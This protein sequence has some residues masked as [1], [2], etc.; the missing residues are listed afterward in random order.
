MNKPLKISLISLGSLIGLIIIALIIVF[1]V[2]LN[3]KRSTTLVN[4]YASKFISCEYEI[5]KV[6]IAFF[7]TFPDVAVEID[8]LTLENK[9]QGCKN[10]TLAF[11]EKCVASLNVKE[12]YNG[13]LVINKLDLHGGSINAFIDENGNSNFDIFAGNEGDDDEND[14]SKSYMID[15]KQ[16]KFND[17]NFVYNDLSSGI[18][19]AVNGMNLNLV[20]VVDEMTIRGDIDLKIK[21]LNADVVYD[22][23]AMSGAAENLELKSNLR[24][25]SEIVACEPW[26]AIG[27]TSF[28]M[29]G[30]SVVS[31]NFDAFA[32]KTK[33]A[34]HDMN[35]LA[36]SFINTKFDGLS[37]SLNDDDYL[38]NA[39]VTVDSKS[40]VEVSL[41][42]KTA[43][44]KDISLII[45]EY[46]VSLA[47]SVAMKDEGIAMN[48]DVNTNTIDV[49]D[50]IEFIPE[51]ILGDALDG[52]SADGKLQIKSKING[53]YNENTTPVVDAELVF[54]D[55]S[56]EMPESLPYPLTEI[57]TLLKVGLDR[58]GKAS[59]AINSLKTKM[60]RSSVSMAGTVSD[61]LRDS[62]RCSLKANIATNAD[63]IRSF[64]P[65]Y[66]GLEGAFTA[67]VEVKGSITDVMDFKFNDSQ[68]DAK[69]M[70]SDMSVNYCD[71]INLVSENLAVNLAY[72]GKGV[73]KE[74]NGYV[75][76][77]VNG[78]DLVAEVSEMM[79]VELD[80][81]DINGYASNLLDYSSVPSIITEFG[82]SRVDFEMDDINLNA[83]YSN[84][85]LAVLRSTNEG[86]V[87][88]TM[89]FGSDSLAFSMD[90][91][92]L[93]TESIALD[94]FSDY[95]EKLDNFMM[96]WNPKFDIDLSNALVDVDGIEETI[97]I[98]SIN[99]KY[100][101]KGL[102]VEDSKVVLG[103]SDFSLEGS[104]TNIAENIKNKELLRGD[105]TFTSGYSD[106][107]Q[108]LT[109]FS[110]MGST[111][112]V[113]EVADAGEE[114][115]PFM[116]PLGTDIRL[117]TLINRA[118]FADVDMKN[119]QGN[120][121]VHDGSLVLQEVGFTTDAATMMLT[122]IYKSPRKNN[123]YVGFDFHLLDIDIA[124]MINLV[125]DIDTIV[126]MLKS[127]EGKAEFHLAAETNL[128]S[129]YSIKYSTLKSACSIEGADLVVL[130]SETFNTIKRKLM[131]NRNTP[132]KIDSLDV[133]FTLFRNEIDVYPFVVSLDKYQVALY[134][135][136]NLDMSYDYNFS[137][138]NPPILNRLGLEVN[139][140]NF[141][142]MH[143]KVR[144][145]MVKNIYNP[146]K[147]DFVEEK[148]LELKRVIS[149]SLK[150]NI[151]ENY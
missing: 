71:T 26:L 114:N 130:D 62:R 125:P 105:F 75:K 142:D 30:S 63:D 25:T 121:T 148:I 5:G 51:A 69:V 141:D 106:V 99:M 86:N 34:L 12:L 132:N 94:V 149:E 7:S 135:R 46:I 145:S 134:G 92:A 28:A 139:G 21:E 78:S 101:D 104:M 76:V 27:N 53:V 8:M 38:D 128:K 14:D 40:K 107:N 112:T 97:I 19:A 84:G 29:N 41:N 117:Y 111:D 82:F 52:I 33:C 96:K 3:P 98:P 143:F 122:A 16:L 66:V 32:L 116:V 129:D 57:N 60:N 17:I 43:N 146:E 39:M 61:A 83:N 120:V 151:K 93:L 31:A 10:D 72:Q 127:F 90:G 64:V 65:D 123:L 50:A 119:V 138:L 81:F 47:G 35:S 36:C 37:V 56:V 24:Y 137:V 58:N 115:G 95:N 45:N 144:R 44:V 54:N 73:N 108:L 67:D 131:F 80:D 49:S 133:Q 1:D 9:V 89:L 88:I 13:N 109:L 113:A 68:F 87:S 55:G 23:T 124:E 150:D 48:L 110:G 79:S 18:A 11:V 103:N 2:V 15:L 22:S 4:N 118:S 147:R 42:E 100:D 126:P 70:C 20:G 77:D 102:L 59:V 136:H 74:A 6:D 91:L 140:P 85:E